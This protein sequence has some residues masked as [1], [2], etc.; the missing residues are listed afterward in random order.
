MENTRQIEIADLTNLLLQ[1]DVVFAENKSRL[2]YGMI[3]LVTNKKG[4][5]LVIYQKTFYVYDSN[6]A[7]NPDALRMISLIQSLFKEITRDEKNRPTPVIIGSYDTSTPYLDIYASVDAETYGKSIGDIMSYSVD[8]VNHS[9]NEHR[10]T[11]E[12]DYNVNIRILK[13]DFEEFVK[14]TNFCDT[15]SVIFDKE[16]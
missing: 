16:N 6:F 8:G 10:M 15:K 7:L 5:A 3:G 11:D 1:R 2:D 13:R 12:D 4:T 9:D 14:Y